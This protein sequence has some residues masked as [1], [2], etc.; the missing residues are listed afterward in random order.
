MSSE[1]A[2]APLDFDV[3][4][5]KDDVLALRPRPNSRAMSCAEYLEFLTQF[6]FSFAALCARRGPHGEPFSLCIRRRR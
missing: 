2:S 1:K 4:T 5:T 6:D 3:P